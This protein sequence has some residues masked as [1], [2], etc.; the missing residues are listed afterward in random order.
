MLEGQDKVT[1]CLRCHDGLMRS[2]GWVKLP[3]WPHR[4][5]QGPEPDG[6]GVTYR[7]DECSM[8]GATELTRQR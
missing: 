4:P 6:V 3:V 1:P 2:G 5:G 7:V 8:C